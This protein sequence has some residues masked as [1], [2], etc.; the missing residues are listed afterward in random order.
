MVDWLKAK[1]E[2]TA[3][4]SAEKHH[5]KAEMTFTTQD[6]CKSRLIHGFVH[7]LEMNHLFSADICVD[8]K[9]IPVLNIIRD[10]NAFP[11]VF[12]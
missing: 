4:E 6:G 12:Q 3:S 2:E 11:T 1:T 9:L 7:I 5:E 8:D 10:T